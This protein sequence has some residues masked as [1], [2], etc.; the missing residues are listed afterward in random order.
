MAGR[1][2][3]RCRGERRDDRRP[4]AHPRPVGHG[5]RARPR[6]RDAGRHDRPAPRA[7]PFANWQD[8]AHLRYGVRGRLAPIRSASQRPGR[9]DHAAAN[10]GADGRAGPA[11]RPWVCWPDRT[12]RRAWGGRFCRS[13]AR[14]D[15]PHRGVCHGRRRRGAGVSGSWVR[16]GGGAV[17]GDVSTLKP[18]R[19]KIAP[20]RRFGCGTGSLFARYAPT[21]INGGRLRI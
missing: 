15:Q 9:G 12:A 7:V 13:G 5:V 18:D 1:V 21:P 17:A 14:P 2:R 4:H 20:D 11:R 6:R 16:R 19:R 10:R 8:R 3:H